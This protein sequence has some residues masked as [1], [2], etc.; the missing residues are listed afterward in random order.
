MEVGDAL[1]M[2]QRQMIVTLVKI[3][4]TKWHPEPQGH[5][6]IANSQPGNAV[7]KSERET[8]SRLPAGRSR[9][10]GLSI[11]RTPEKIHLYLNFMIIS[12]LEF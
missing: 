10:S 8:K 7:K 1:N 11:A 9:S 6:V 5:E 2:A 3:L 12:R 4:T